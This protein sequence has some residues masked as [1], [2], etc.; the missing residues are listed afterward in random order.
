MCLCQFCETDIGDEFHYFLCWAHFKEECREYIEAKYYIRPSTIYLQELFKQAKGE[1]LK[2]LAIFAKIIICKFQKW[3][4]IYIVSCANALLVT[5][6]LLVTCYLLPDIRK[7]L[8]NKAENPYLSQK[9]MKYYIA[10]YNTLA[11]DLT[12]ILNLTIV[13]STT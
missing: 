9:N 12:M 10:N 8:L 2:Q 5:Y 11:A 13:S 6:L 3:P 4:C 1:K 7:G